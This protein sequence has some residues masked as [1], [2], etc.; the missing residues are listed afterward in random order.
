MRALISKRTRQA[1]ADKK[2]AGQRVGTAPYG[3]FW[4]GAVLMQDPAKQ[5]VIREILCCH[6]GGMNYLEIADS[7]NRARIPGPKNAGWHRNTVRRIIRR[8]CGVVPGSVA[9]RPDPDKA[10]R[11]IR[12]LRADERSY[13]QIAR[14]LNARGLAAPRG[15]IWHA[16]TVLTALRHMN[17]G[18]QETP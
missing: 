12:V 4:C 7:L 8:T 14:Q 17:E 15:G 18:R 5:A 1:L 13:R 16:A 11:I 10:S 9:R 6:R 3:M 2:A